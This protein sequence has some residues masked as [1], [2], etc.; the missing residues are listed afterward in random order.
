[1]QTIEESK[2]VKFVRRLTN[3]VNFP[4]ITDLSRIVDSNPNLFS[5]LIGAVSAAYNTGEQ[6]LDLQ[7]GVYTYLPGVKSEDLKP[8]LEAVHKFGR[9]KSG[10]LKIY[11]F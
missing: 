7:P 9:R 2:L 1:M 8:F 4:N 6:G 5:Y 3:D 11:P 10:R